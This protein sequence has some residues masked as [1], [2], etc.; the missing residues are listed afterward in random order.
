[1]NGI[2]LAGGTGSRLLPLTASVNKHLLPVHK[3]FMIEY[4]LEMM[5]A[6]G[7]RR[8]RVVTT[9]DAVGPLA[10]MFG[11]GAGLGLQLSYRVQDTPG[12]VAEALLVGAAPGDPAPTLV[13]LG[14][15]VFESADPVV[16]RVGRFGEGCLVFA[17]RVDDVA[18]YG[19]ILPAADPHAIRRVHEKPLGPRPG[20]ASTGLY[21]FDGKLAHVLAQALAR[22]QGPAPLGMA[23]AI[24]WYADHYLAHYCEYPGWWYDVGTHAALRQCADALAARE[25][26]PR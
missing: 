8:V 10:K 17:K 7:V 16:A 1:M 13:S 9:A 3:R 26:P 22:H 11:S 25:S 5:K 20:L 24:N 23:D 2:I 18:P 14:D 12:S 4:P 15:Q 19:E 21:V 6:C